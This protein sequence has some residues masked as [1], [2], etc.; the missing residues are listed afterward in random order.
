MILILNLDQDST[1][2]VL[3]EDCI[4]C[5]E[6]QYNM[7]SKKRWGEIEAIIE[8]DVKEINEELLESLL[9]KLS[10][11]GPMKLHQPYSSED[12]NPVDVPKECIK[13]EENVIQS[14][15]L[16][17]KIRNHNCPG[18]NSSSLA[19]MEEEANASS[20]EKPMDLDGADQ[21][22][23]MYQY[24]IQHN[25]FDLGYGSFAQGPRSSPPEL[26]PH[27]ARKILQKSVAALLAHTGYETA[28]LSALDTLTDISQHF[29]QHLSKLLCFADAVEWAF[30]EAGLG[31]V[32][33]LH[34][35]YQENIIGYRS[36]LESIV[37]NL[38]PPP[39]PSMLQSGQDLISEEDDVP[40]I[41]FPALGNGEASE[42]MQSTLEPGFQM[43]HSLEEEALQG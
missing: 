36:H 11:G 23:K 21:S 32:T 33:N 15:K 3:I 30:F 31:S 24:K 1:L 6:L 16:L 10:L 9:T 14:I 39:P 7:A 40:E 29:L 18:N 20:Q 27:V 28:K 35:Y 38:P 34:T 17:E 37:A 19:S 43:L 4:L 5:Q 22:E 13:M 26:R 8:E 2:A 12:G 42:E 25:L 41:H